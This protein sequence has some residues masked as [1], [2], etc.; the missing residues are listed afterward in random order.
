M[1]DMLKDNPGVQAIYLKAAE[2]GVFPVPTV[3]QTVLGSCLG[4]VF[5]TVKTTASSSTLPAMA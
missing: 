5:V 4:G 2:G 1:S 3:V